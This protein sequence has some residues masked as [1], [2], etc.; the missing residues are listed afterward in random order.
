MGKYD[1]NSLL[2]ELEKTETSSGGNEYQSDFWKPTI[3]KGEEEVEYL[4]R[5]LPNPDSKTNFPWVERAA[6]MFN[7]PSGKF[8][9]EPCAKKSKKEP[10]YVC[11]EVSKLYQSGD[12]K[13]EALGSKRFS[14]KRFFHN[15]LVVKDPREGGKNEGKVFI[16][17]AGSQIHDKCIEILKNDDLDANERV[18]FH[19]TLGTDFKLRITWKSN[20]QNYDKSTFARRTSSLEVK[21]EKLD[22]DAAETF[23]DEN[24]I[25]LNKRLLGE[26]A[27]KGYEDL[28]E[29]YLNQGN[30]TEKKEPRKEKEAEEIEVDEVEELDTTVNDEK[31]QAQNPEPKKKVEPVEEEDDT[32]FDMDDDSSDEDA[33]LEALLSDD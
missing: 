6:H 12:V 23:I 33:E 4:I 29:L 8:I 28:K 15:I 20:Y 22:D 13:Q 9:Y 5:F 16:Y 17:E 7:F 11:E 30:V 14:K 31:I 19:P 32:P 1:L 27:F 10:C 26:K 18:Y 21:G 3:E 25:G 24:C 2:N